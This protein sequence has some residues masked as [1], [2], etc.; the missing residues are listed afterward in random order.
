MFKEAFP[1]IIICLCLLGLLIAYSSSIAHATLTTSTVSHSTTLAVTTH[2]LS[3]QDSSLPPPNIGNTTAFDLPG[4]LH[5]DSYAVSCALGVGGYRNAVV[6]SS[7]RLEYDSG[8]IQ[9]MS[10]YLSQ[11]IRPNPADASNLPAPPSTLNETS[12]SLV[13]TDPSKITCSSSLQITNIATRAVQITGAN[14]LLLSN[15][16]PNQY[17]Y[18][19]I[20][21]CSLP[22]SAI[23][24]T[25]PLCPPLGGAGLLFQ[26]NFNLSMAPA[27]T[28]FPGQPTGA[29]PFLINPG[30]VAYILLNYGSSANL[31]YS[32]APEINVSLMNQQSTFTLSQLTSNLAFVKPDQLSCYQLQGNAFTQINLNTSGASCL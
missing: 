29:Q 9:Q 23:S 5:V 1:R 2:P 7:D 18:R 12:A 15:A 17:Q 31:I 14:M 25:N 4:L 27:N 6:L 19:L 11:S 16:Q 32:V 3:T 8:E 30:Q 20:D 26:Y 21:A 24:G 28:T 10:T 22:P 13:G